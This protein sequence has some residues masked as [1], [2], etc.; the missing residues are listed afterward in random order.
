MLAWSGEGMRWG[1]SQSG[2]ISERLLAETVAQSWASLVV[3]ASDCG[4]IG[5]GLLFTDR[6]RCN[7][8]GSVR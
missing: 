7:A 3:A 6:Q 4:V 1:V 8:L 5:W 2:L